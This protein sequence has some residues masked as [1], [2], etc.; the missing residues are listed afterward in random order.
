[1]T[2][3]TNLKGSA[4]S[5]IEQP[6]T[7][8]E[9]PTHSALSTEKKRVVFSPHPDNSP[10][11]F[12]PKHGI[13]K[14][15]ILK[16]STL[17]SENNPSDAFPPVTNKSSIKDLSSLF[18]QWLVALEDSDRRRR[19]ETYSA[20]TPFIKSYTVHPENDPFLRVLDRFCEA[21]KRD[22]SSV[23][24]TGVHD[25]QLMTQANRLLSTLLW[26]PSISQNIKLDDAKF[27]IEHSV[28]ALESKQLTKPAA[29]QHLHL[30]ACQRCNTVITAALCDRIITSCLGVSFPSI[31]VGQEQISV[32]IKMLSQCPQNLSHR[33]MDWAPCLMSC[34][35]DA[36]KAIREKALLWSLETGHV[37]YRD[38]LVARAVLACLR[39]AVNEKLFVQLVYERFQTIATEEDDGVFVSH[40]WAAIITILGGSRIS[41]WE[42]F[43]TWLKVIQVCF[44]STNPLTKCAAQTAWIRLI[45]E[46]SSFDSVAQASK[47][48]A[49]LCQPIAM[50][51]KT[52]N[53][54][55]VKHAAMNALIALLYATLRP[56][57]TNSIMDLLWN[58]VIQ[59]LIENTAL[60]N[61]YSM[62]ESVNILLALFDTSSTIFWREDR[63]LS[64]DLVQSDEL[65]KISSKWVRTNCDLTVKPVEAVLY[66]AKPQRALRS[67][68]RKHYLIGG[69]PYQQ[70]HRLW[71]TYIKCL[72]S[73]GLKEIKTSDETILTMC[74]ISNALFRFLH[75]NPLKEFETLVERIPRYAE[76]VKGV[77]EAFGVKLCIEKAYYE[78]SEELKPLAS[79]GSDANSDV[80]LT[81]PF[82]YWLKTL[83]PLAN[84]SMFT[85]VHTA[86]S[87]VYEYL[88]NSAMG[89]TTKLQTLFDCTSI[90]GESDDLTLARVLVSHEVT[91]LAIRSLSSVLDKLSTSRGTGSIDDDFKNEWDLLFQILCWCAKNCSL[92]DSDSVNTLLEHFAKMVSSLEGE[93]SVIDIV[94]EPFSAVLFEKLSVEN[95]RVY[96]FTMTLMKLSV[97][98]VSL[99]APLAGKHME[100]IHGESVLSEC[101]FPKITL[102]LIDKVLL[103]LRSTGQPDLQLRFIKEIISFL[104]LVPRVVLA[105]FLLTMLDSLGAWIKIDFSNLPKEREIIEKL[106]A[107]VFDRL[108]ELSDSPNFILQ[109]LFPLLIDGLTSTSKANQAIAINFWNEVLG[110]FDANEYPTQLL[111]TLIKVSQTGHI[112][113]PPSQIDHFDILPE[114]VLPGIKDLHGKSS[115]DATKFPDTA[116]AIIDESTEQTS[117]EEKAKPLADNPVE[118]NKEAPS[119]ETDETDMQYSDDDTEDEENS[120]AEVLRVSKLKKS[121]QNAKKKVHVEEKINILSAPETDT[122]ADTVPNNDEA[123]NSS[124]SSTEAVEPTVEEKEIRLD[125]VP[126]AWIASATSSS[127]KRRSDKAPPVTNSPKPTKKRKTAVQPI[128]TVPTSPRKK[129]DKKS[130]EQLMTRRDALD[131]LG[132]AIVN[133]EQ[134]IDDFQPNELK[135][136]GSFLIR[137]QQSL[138]SKF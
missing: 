34:L 19:V 64:R 118:L 75:K 13:P 84:G 61:D 98:P 33:A 96:S 72:A 66:V 102:S 43:N 122:N 9:K 32:L 48:F 106:S 18:S 99:Y 51:L 113:I 37:L 90:L 78:E 82:V 132:E 117:T 28:V 47:R 138:F 136:L 129:L 73:A 55:T 50:V 8:A 116:P 103:Y 87:A 16:S 62:A 71:N 17:H 95:Y 79:K 46:F 59:N 44:N 10:G 54:S 97:F 107:T 45:H 23:S 111:E 60:K 100:V 24:N 63:L 80:T 20:V 5:V 6:R 83:L 127:R 57:I 38:K 14:K 125:D 110:G 124:Q 52:R 36:N 67:T 105:D 1:M 3:Y 30:L 42:H 2:Q 35:I 70:S 109:Y 115:I 56:G 93:A 22:I 108:R 12:L 89:L 114:I 77:L 41:S 133:V 126:V 94:I 40:A 85:T 91:A 137:L 29:V 92:S 53:S 27:F 120:L 135:Q 65:P 104:Q 4:A 49:L 76:L 112:V 68:P 7:P 11:G 25:F 39:E 21:L 101:K 81:S 88:A 58:M 69:I 31:L 123:I 74:C 131:T 119:V 128:V 86:F 121:R 134:I 15:S 130:L 26:H